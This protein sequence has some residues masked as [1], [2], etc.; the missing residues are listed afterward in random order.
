[1]ILSHFKKEQLSN[2]FH[3]G[4]KVPPWEPLSGNSGVL[5]TETD[6]ILDVE[7]TKLVGRMGVTKISVEDYGELK[8]N[9]PLPPSVRRFNQDSIKVIKPFSN[10]A[11]QASSTL[12]S[13]A[14]A[15]APSVAPR[16]AAVSTDYAPRLGK[17]KEVPTAA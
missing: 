12:S 4:G 8:K 3:I 11:P 6:S 10:K 9:R 5:A 7:L 16:D 14:A 2:L 13:A 15:P 1:M 17:L